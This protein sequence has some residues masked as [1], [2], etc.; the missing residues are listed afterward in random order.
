MSDPYNTQQYANQRYTKEGWQ[1]LA[2]L[3]DR[4][5]V[6]SYDA[7]LQPDKRNWLSFKSIQG[8]TFR[9]V[10]LAEAFTLCKYAVDGSSVEFICDLRRCEYYRLL[11]QIDRISKGG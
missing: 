3:V 10:E 5:K 6:V 4:N 9:F 1:Q 7:K 8:A 2:G 11:H